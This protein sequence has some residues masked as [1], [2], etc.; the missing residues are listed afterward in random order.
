MITPADNL[1][2]LDGL[3]FPDFNI[4]RTANLAVA[5]ANYFGL[6]FGLFMIAAPMMGWIDYRSP[7]LGAALCFG[8]ICEYIFGIL[9]WY[10]RRTIQSFI[11]FVF[12][13]LH[14]AVF[15]T[16][17]LGMYQIPVPIFYH[18]YMQGVFYIIW[19]VMLLIV[20]ISLR[21]RGLLYMINIFLLIF[22]T[23]FVIVWEF[24]KRTWARKF[25]GYLIFFASILIWL[26]ALLK[27]INEMM[28]GPVVPFV[29]PRI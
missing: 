7:T 29:V 13:L 19:F 8:G 6:A 5:P 16:T 9:N 21:D 3:V 1:V 2:I 4:K 12:G 17:D 20:M 25:A 28:R 15:Y 14:L 11:D 10:Q 27:L 24:S 23:I 26:T 22:A 18:T